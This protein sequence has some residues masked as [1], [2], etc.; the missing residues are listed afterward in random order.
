MLC[1]LI[2]IFPGNMCENYE[3]QTIGQTRIYENKEGK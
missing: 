2:T 1:P 3:E